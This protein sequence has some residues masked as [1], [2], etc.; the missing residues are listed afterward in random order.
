MLLARRRWRIYIKLI[1]EQKIQAKD[2]MAKQTCKSQCCK[3]S[4]KAKN[5]ENNGLMSPYQGL[6]YKRN[7]SGGCLQNQNKSLKKKKE[8]KRNEPK[9][10][11]LISV[12][13][14]IYGNI[15]T[16]SCGANRRWECKGES[17]AT[18][19]VLQIHHTPQTPA[20]RGGHMQCPMKHF[21]ARANHFK[22]K[23]R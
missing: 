6:Y 19:A 20:E 21:T 13:M 4:G 17:S 8:V 3:L 9:S 2:G 11:S 5:S 14:S 15:H 1:Q 10:K 7:D 18:M 23:P 22:W 16:H 12:C